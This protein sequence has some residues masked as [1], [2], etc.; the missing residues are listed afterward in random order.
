LQIRRIDLSK[1]EIFHTILRNQ[2]TLTPVFSRAVYFHFT[3][4]KWRH[5][6][7]RCVGLFSYLPYVHCLKFLTGRYI[8][9]FVNKAS[10]DKG[11]ACASGNGAIGY[12]RIL[13]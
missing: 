3:N 1:F 9:D 2:S 10:C 11:R 5:W 8:V 12:R 4:L 7:D 6:F 13:P